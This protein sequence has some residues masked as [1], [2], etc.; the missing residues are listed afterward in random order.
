MLLEQGTMIVVVGAVIGAGAFLVFARL[1]TDLVFGVPVV[2]G[3]AI[4]AASF[5]VFGVAMLA[6]WLPARRAARVDL[7]TALKAE[8]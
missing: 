8:S 7:M 3:A 2:D 1:L 4:A 5:V 6:T